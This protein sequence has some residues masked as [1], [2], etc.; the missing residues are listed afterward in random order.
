MFGDNVGIFLK[1]L[2]DE[3]YGPSLFSNRVDNDLDNSS[4]DTYITI[5]PLLLAELIIILQILLLHSLKHETSTIKFQVSY[6]L[7]LMP[8]VQ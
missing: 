4:H 5:I 3:F 1:N 7:F 2:E 8:A 6:R